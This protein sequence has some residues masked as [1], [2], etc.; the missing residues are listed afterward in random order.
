MVIIMDTSSGKRMTDEQ[1][2]DRYG[3]EVLNASWLPCPELQAGL[4]AVE[5]AR[6][7]TP[8]TDPETF[9]RNVYLCQE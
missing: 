2:E 7:E 8:I 9:L 6:S 5:P 1:T 4:Q 3:D